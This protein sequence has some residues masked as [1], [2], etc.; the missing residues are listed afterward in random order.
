MRAPQQIL[1]ATCIGLCALLGPGRAQSGETGD[2][3]LE[4]PVKAAFLVNFAKFAEWPAESH[5]AQAP[6]VSI[7]VLGRD[8]FGEVLERAV[9]GRSVGGRPIVIQRLRNADELA[10][11][12]VL[13]IA[14]SES[15]RLARIL[16]GLAGQPV[17]TVGECDGFA[18]Q[19]GV[20]GLIV[21][22]NSARFEVNLQAAQQNRLLLSSKL[23]AV[24]RMVDGPKAPER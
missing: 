15:P 21:E 11:C 1:A 14:T 6:A 13:F 12:H 16:V 10:A 5:Q 8:P 18:R 9:A 22:D 4:Y 20:I 24:A 23:L 2:R 17:L 7:C 19:G 3:S